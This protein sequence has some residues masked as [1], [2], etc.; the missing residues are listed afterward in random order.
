MDDVYLRA[1]KDCKCSLLSL[2]LLLTVLWLQPWESLS[3]LAQRIE[4]LHHKAISTTE[5]YLLFLS[6][7]VYDIIM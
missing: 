7:V 6:V 2:M 5:Y 1:E 4:R 3:S